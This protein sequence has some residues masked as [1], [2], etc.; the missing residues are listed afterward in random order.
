MKLG[1]SL[2]LGGASATSAAAG[3]Y[4]FL[5]SKGAIIKEELKSF[6]LISN[7]DASAQVKQWQEEFKSDQESIKKAI[8][9]LKDVSTPE[10][11]GKKLGEWCSS[12]MDLDS[13]KH[14]DTFELV[15][16]YCLIR[17]LSSQLKRNNKS[18][19]GKGQ[20]SEWKAVY[21][22]RKSK[23]STRADVGITDT[24]WPTNNDKDAEELLVIQAWCEKT[25]KEDFLASDNNSK[26]DKLLKWCTVDGKTAD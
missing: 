15:K 17:D 24:N 6:K 22:Q 12:Q 7:L 4:Y 10:D 18:V 25:E 16:K 19:L 26:Y 11:G 9:T 1:S 21:Q 5:S 14:S 8:P 13:K 23:K 2:L 3:G 20:D